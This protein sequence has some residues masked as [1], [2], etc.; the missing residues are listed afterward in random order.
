MSVGYTAVQSQN[1]ISAYFTSKQIQPFGFA[2]QHK[3]IV[4]IFENMQTLYEDCPSKHDA[5]PQ[6][7][8]ND[9]PRLRRQPN[10]NPALGQ[11][12]LFSGVFVK[13]NDV[14]IPY[15]DMI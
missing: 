1:A 9:G 2:E 15:T 14:L 6:C 13:Y 8:V 3:P 12:I 5:L 10:I 11:C 4:H 7:W